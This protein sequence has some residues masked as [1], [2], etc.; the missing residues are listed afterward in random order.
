MPGCCVRIG[1]RGQRTRSTDGP[2]RPRSRI[3]RVADRCTGGPR[4]RPAGRGRTAARRRSRTVRRTGAAGAAGLGGAIGRC[5]GTRRRD[6]GSGGVG[7]VGRC[8]SMRSRS[9][10][11]TIRPGAGGFGRRRAG[12][13]RGGDRRRGCG[14]FGDR[15][16]GLRC[17][18]G[19][20]RRSCA[21][22]AAYRRW[23]GDRD[24]RRLR[25]GGSGDRGASTGPVS[26]RRSGSGSA[27]GG[28]T[29]ASF[30]VLT[31]RGGGSAGA[32]GFTGSGAFFA[33]AGF[34]PLAAGVS[35]KML[36]ARQRDVRAAAR[37]GR[38]TGARRLPRSCSRRS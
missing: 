37:G 7:V 30:A 22:S 23:L 25:A 6:V 24:R 12:G 29:D 36:P 35:A 38:R 21:A 1:L 4:T 27:T 11:G 3:R 10:G 20:R 14:R 31:R 33:G 19:A 2:L 15:R 8:S 28:A 32:A 9:V 17:G 13:R 34:L 18:R 5:N 16:R 26:A